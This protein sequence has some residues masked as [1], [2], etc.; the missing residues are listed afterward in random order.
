MT[1]WLWRRLREE[2]GSSL[3]EGLLALGLVVLVV[4]IGVE[5]FAYMQARSVATA[6]A[7]DGAEAAATGGPAAGIARARQVLAAG[8]GAS[9]Q[10]SPS[11]AESFGMVTVTVSGKA[12][13]VFSL[14]LL[15]PSVRASATLPLEQYAADEQAVAP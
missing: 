4:V 9:G 11:V 10:L 1:I 6:A 2:R 13:S 8:G 3:V 15:L 5:G 14:G 7:Q 12:P